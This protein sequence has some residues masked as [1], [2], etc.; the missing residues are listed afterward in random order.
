MSEIAAH[1]VFS[2]K[3]KERTDDFSFFPLSEVLSFWSGFKCRTQIHLRAFSD[4]FPVRYI[5]AQSLIEKLCYDAEVHSRELFFRLT[6]HVV[7]QNLNVR[8]RKI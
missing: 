6:C 5:L 4:L 2:I 7:S 8:C 3:K 1:G